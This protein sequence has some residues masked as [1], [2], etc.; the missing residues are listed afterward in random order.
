MSQTHENE[1]TVGEVSYTVTGTNFALYNQG[2][3]Y[4]IKVQ[5][6]ERY[7]NYELPS[8]EQLST[9]PVTDGELVV[10]NNLV[11]SRPGSAYFEENEADQSIVT[12]YFMAGMPNTDVSSNFQSTLSL[13]Y[14]LNTVDYPITDYL[15]NGII[16]GSK[17]SGGQTFETAGPEIPDIILRDPPGSESFAT[18]EQGSSFSSSREY[19]GAVGS[20]IGASIGVKVG[21]K[22]GVGGG[23]LG[24]LIESESYVQGTTGINFGFSSNFGNEL[25]TNYSFSQS[26]S[27]SDDPDW[28]GADADLYIGTSYNQFYGVMD[29]IEPTLAQVT[30]TNSAVVSIPVNTTSGTIY[31]SKNKALFFSPGDE[32]TVFIYS[33]RQILTDIIPFYTEIYDN[34]D[35]IVN[36]TDPCPISIDGDIKP[37]VWY[38]SQIKLWRRVIQINEETKYLANSDREGLRQRIESDFQTYFT[39][40]DTEGQSNDSGTFFN[41]AG[42]TLN[43][44]FQENFFENISFDSGL[45]EFTKTVGTG[46]TDVNEYTVGFEI[47]QSNELE[48]VLDYGGNGGTIKV[49]NKNTASFEYTNND[50]TETTLDISFTLKDGDDYNKFSIDVVNAFDGNGPVF[51]TKGGET[52]CPVEEAT[53]SYFFHPEQ[54]PVA[55]DSA[56]SIL[57]LAEN[58]RVEI[59]KGTIAIEVP[60]IEVENA[61]VSNIQQATLQNLYACATIL[62]LNLK[63]QNL[64][65]C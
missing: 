25:T 3:K 53:F 19:A 63:S 41:P 7:F 34:Y 45:G 56:T 39:P 46:K 44:M 4:S 64:F 26:I 30:D 27:T 12:Y 20:T 15:S 1:I 59:S 48:V 47:E 40:G 52:S 13:L 49:E 23:L 65:L 22:V 9:V 18:I 16:I 31:I 58:Q 36:N 32:R 54:Q 51:V 60:Y 29:N 10:T 62:S 37:R 24:P 28:V 11:D 38:D 2:G 14:R 50:E 43:R 33:Q 42:E 6:L 17:S 5:K 21:L 8:N 61:S 55:E 57:T 35:C